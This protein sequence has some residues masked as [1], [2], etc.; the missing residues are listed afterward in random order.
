MKPSPSR[1]FVV[2]LLCAPV[3]HGAV[4]C[5]ELALAIAAKLDAAGVKDYS[6]E[7]VPN[8]L[9]EGE[10]VVGSCEGGTRKITYAKVKPKKPDAPASP[11]KN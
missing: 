10:K 4:P 7:I 11:P 6:L 2:A 3:A 5:E 8:E 9:A 1:L